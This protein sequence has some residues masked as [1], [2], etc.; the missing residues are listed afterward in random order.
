MNDK[1]EWG[2]EQGRPETYG[3]V[4]EARKAR[5]ARK[6]TKPEEPEGGEAAA[7]LRK[8]LGRQ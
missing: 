4:E 8:A 6:A 5:D 2:E 1:I 7:A 3:S